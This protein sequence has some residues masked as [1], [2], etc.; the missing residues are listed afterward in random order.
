[1]LFRLLAYPLVSGNGRKRDPN[2]FKAFFQIDVILLNFT[3][4]S[5]LFLDRIDSDIRDVYEKRLKA[6][7]CFLAIQSDFFL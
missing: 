3:S 2:K 5:Q 7:H 4:T 6:F 1:M